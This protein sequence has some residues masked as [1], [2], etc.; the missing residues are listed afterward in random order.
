MP[1]F[2]ISDLKQLY[3]YI[4]SHD[5]FHYKFDTVMTNPEG[6][7]V[8]AVLQVVGHEKSGPYELAAYNIA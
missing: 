5:E 7:T 4:P 1:N 8:R 6:K 3:A 2:Q